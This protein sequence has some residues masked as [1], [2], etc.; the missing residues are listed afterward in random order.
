MT[1]PKRNTITAHKQPA[2]KSDAKPLTIGQ[3]QSFDI[4]PRSQV[5]PPVTARPV[6]TPTKPE[7]SDNTLQS[8]TQAATS[9]LKHGTLSFTPSAPEL[10]DNDAEA[11]LGKVASISQEVGR[12]KAPAEPKR[13]EPQLESDGSVAEATQDEADGTTAP[14]LKL[15]PEPTKES[16]GA[17]EAEAEDAEKPEATTPI[18]DVETAETEQKPSEAPKPAD[19]SIDHIFK[20]DPQQTIEH[21]QALKDE[22]QSMGDKPEED[23]HPHHELYG[24]KPVIVIHKAHGAQATLNWILWVIFCLLLALVIVD[25]LLD[26]GVIST[27]YNVPH[28]HYLQ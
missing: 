21:S 28:T 22:L 18:T 2:T 20:E 1:T 5:R 14:G 12:Q 13:E 19:G 10:D 17:V 11:L 27:D 8:A 9:Q 26:A 16:E 4:I 15:A 24:G 3:G 6:L 7:Q 23:T 25:A